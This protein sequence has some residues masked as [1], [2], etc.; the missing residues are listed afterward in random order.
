[1]NL[2]KY[3]RQLVKL[4]NALNLTKLVKGESIFK[5]HPTYHSKCHGILVLYELT[6][7]K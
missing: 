7:Q 2:I 3:S 6:T 4:S 1:M 5:V